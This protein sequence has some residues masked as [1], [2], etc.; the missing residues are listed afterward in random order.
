MQDSLVDP[1]VGEVSPGSS[2]LG[3]FNLKGSKMSSHADGS[4]S[5]KG[6]G[7]SRG[8]DMVHVARDKF[9]SLRYG[10]KWGERGRNGGRKGGKWGHDGNEWGEVEVSGR[11]GQ[12]RDERRGG[13]S[14]DE[15]AHPHLDSYPPGAAGK[16]G[17]DRIG[18]GGG[19][20]GGEER[21]ASNSK[22]GGKGGENQST[23]PE[24]GGGGG[25]KT[26]KGARGKGGRGRERGG[27]GEEGGG[28]DS[29]SVRGRK[30]GTSG[31]KTATSSSPLRGRKA[32]S[33][34]DFPVRRTRSSGSDS[35][36][37][38]RRSFGRNTYLVRNTDIVR[39]TA[40]KMG[41]ESSFDES[42]SRWNAQDGDEE[43]EK[44]GAISRTS[45][46]GSESGA[47][48]SR[49]SVVIEYLP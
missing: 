6:W 10:F 8:Q 26:K 38:P 46:G 31:R 12:G 25:K 21:G 41:P 47:N 48:K 42:I 36:L 39:N 11:D 3:S 1:M 44:G 22:K 28:G 5:G 7:I 30:A 37:S 14:E 19:E 17:V 29:K 32:A 33:R 27:G 2:L 43:R 15:L 24:G 23:W 49:R 4:G 40:S 35:A 16:K 18:V 34:S 45:S 20:E 9:L 13:M